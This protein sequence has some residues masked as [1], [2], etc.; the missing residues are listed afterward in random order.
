[1]P[2]FA[3][4][5]T[6][7]S[8]VKSDIAI[9]LGLTLLSI[10]AVGSGVASASDR[11]LSPSGQFVIYGDDAAGRGAVSSL[12]EQTKANLLAL[13]QRRD[14]W[15]IPA[16]IN[17]Q[18]RAPN[19]PEIP[20]AALRF[21]QTGAGLKLQLDLVVGQEM[22]TEMVE[23][24]ILRVLLLEMI[25]RNQ[26]GIPAGEAYVK[27]PEWLIDG[28]CALA[29]N[30]NRASLVQGLTITERVMPLEE[31]LAQRVNLLDPIG[32]SLHR[33]YSFA[34]VQLLAQN[35]AQLGRYIDNLAFASN[36][37]LA[38]LQKNFSQLAGGD[39]EKIWKAKIAGIRESAR[40]DL[41]SFFQSE[42][43]LEALLQ[44]KFQAPKDRGGSL[45]M[46]EACRTKL[47]PDQRL[48]LKKFSDELML[49][50]ARANP[51]L[52]PIV[53][54]YQRL[55]ARVALGKNRGVPAKLR[56]LKVLREQLSA[57]MSE[58]DDYLNWF[59]ATQLQTQSGLFENANVSLNTA[60][61]RPRRKDNFSI[62]LDA[63]EA[64]F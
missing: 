46:E 9:S 5:A 11:S 49:L 55:A 41:L 18:S 38:D 56:E 39:F 52:R 57:R 6:A 1:M 50:A 4:L 63:M 15:K 45:S 14:Q 44:R 21:S 32:R 64:Q 62:Y 10:F 33:A 13:L 3:I 24:E 2:C 37:P 35:P 22:N 60:A 51:A 61:P 16:V 59:E 54:D 53:Q 34:L 42:E 29:P 26:T 40:Q 23:R 27:P 28:L 7:V 43:K 58:I 30:R 47:T 48:T 19:I 20:N 25:Y 17:L 36:D 12:A 31:F 8:K